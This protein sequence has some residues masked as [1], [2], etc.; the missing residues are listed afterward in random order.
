MSSEPELMMN[1]LNPHFGVLGEGEKTIVELAQA[2][3]STRKFAAVNGLVF[4]EPAM[5]PAT[6]W[7]RAPIRDLDSLPLP[8]EEVCSRAIMRAVRNPITSLAAAPVPTSALF[9]TIPP[10]I[11]TASAAWTACFARSNTARANIRRHTIPSSTS[12]S[13]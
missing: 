5:H 4:R 9:V 10:A 2:L 6:T 13:L 12:C 3:T 7:A 8:D 11:A 1:S